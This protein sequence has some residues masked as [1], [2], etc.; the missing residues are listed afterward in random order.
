MRS[1]HHGRL[2]GTGSDGRVVLP[3][4]HRCR[5][6]GLL[7]VAAPVV[8]VACGSSPKTPVAAGGSSTTITTSSTI[9]STTTEPAPLTL[10]GTGVRGRVTA[11]PTCPV[12][13]PDQPCPP[14]PVHGRVD[15]VNSAG[16]TAGSATTDDAGRFAIT[17]P[18]GDY[19]LR[20]VTD[21]SFP[22][23]SDVSVTVTAGP[24]A[25]ADIDCD[26]GIR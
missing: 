19:T 10:D 26:T 13:R 20:V 25:T 8:L 6:I 21:G 4:V 23:C 11:G 18:Q 1:C 9:P 24:P 22:Q 5:L 7:L 12:E 14:S 3:D 16:N 17:L 2:P 15:A